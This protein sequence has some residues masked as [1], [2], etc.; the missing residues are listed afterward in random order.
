M[1]I[2]LNKIT[3]LLMVDTGNMA[4]FLS[5]SSVNSIKMSGGKYSS[6]LT[7]NSQKSVK[8][9]FFSLQYKL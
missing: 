7:I 5:R 8:L 2:P 3:S 9:H 6:D 4:D 1:M